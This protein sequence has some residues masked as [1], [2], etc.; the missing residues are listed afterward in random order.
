MVISVVITLVTDYIVL[1]TTTTVFSVPGYIALVEHNY[2]A[3]CLILL[4]TATIVYKHRMNYVRI[5]NGTEIGLRSAAKGE[6][7]VR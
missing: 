3:V 1:A 2:I 5:W 6:H 7:R 4:A